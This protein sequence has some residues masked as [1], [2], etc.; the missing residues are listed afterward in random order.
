MKKVL[1]MMAVAAFFAMSATA[2]GAEDAAADEAKDGENT[3]E[4]APEE[5]H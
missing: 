5:A 2:C 1:T 3:E 4:K